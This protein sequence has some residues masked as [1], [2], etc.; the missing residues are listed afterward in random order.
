MRVALVHDY[1][2]RLR[3]GERIFLALARMFPG[4]D[5][6]TLVGDSR[7]L[8]ADERPPHMHASF[9]RFIPGSAQHYRAL[10]PLY[11]VAARSLDLRDYDLV[12]SSS[13]G[14]CHAVRTSGTHV[15]YCHTPLRYAWT[16]FDTTVRRQKMRMARAA[17]GLTLGYIRRQD[18]AAAQRVTRYVANSTAVQKRIAGCYGRSSAVVYPFV[19]VARF[20][21]VRD[22]AD[23]SDPYFLIV[24]QLLPY[25]R[26]DLAVEA[27]TR[28]HL[29]LLIVGTGPELPRLSRMAGATVRFLGRVST[30]ELAGLYAGCTAFLQCGEEDFGISAL[31]AQASG[32]PVIAFRA[33]G[34]LD[35][36]LEGVTGRLFA[37]QSADG[38]LGILAD[39][40]PGDF[41]ARA[42]RI[43]AERFGESR[44][45]EGIAREV[46]A[47]LALQSSDSAAVRTTLLSGH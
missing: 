38:L 24:S 32:R 8:P 22:A 12:I 46:D 31:E 19:D 10:L 25:K 5:C 21:P 34:A 13:S 43:H 26:V 33:S 28:L 41:D 45:R 39:F 23:Q 3:G 7:W 37:D 9:L 4:A 11:P 20:R 1:V 42:V 15:C 30:G 18:Y 40:D 14:F 47:A 16:V 6:Y 17:L 44:F 27:C 2:V 29:P 35:T 36:V